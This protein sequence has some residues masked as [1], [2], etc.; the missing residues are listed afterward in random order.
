MYAR[1]GSEH[2]H[3]WV[4]TVDLSLDELLAA[5][6][7]GRT[8]PGL[9]LLCRAHIAMSPDAASMVAAYESLGGALLL[10]EPTDGTPAMDY[11]ALLARLDE[12]ALAAPAAAPTDDESPLPHAVTSA[13]GMKFEDIPWRRRLPGIAEHVLAGY[14]GERVSLLRA[15][16]G[17]AI[18]QHTHEGAELT[19]V[20]AGALWDGGKIFRPGDVAIAGPEH[21]HH[22]EIIGDDICYCLAV[23]DGGLRFTGRFGRALN[24]L[25]E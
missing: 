12:D 22:P 9:T 24:F 15:R 5:Y 1:N 16:P 25:A 20:L 10:S 13:L 23:L 2:S 17:S 8:T 21:D 19:L 11:D 7:A 14:G 18:P 3:G 6:A 4:S